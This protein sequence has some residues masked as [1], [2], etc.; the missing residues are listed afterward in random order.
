MVSRA[1]GSGIPLGV[2]EHVMVFSPAPELTVTIE[3]GGSG[4]DARHPDIH[5]HAGGQGVWQ[6]RMIRSLDVPVVMC[7]VLGGEPGRV[8]APLIKAE[9]IDLRAVQATERNPA[10]V[11]DRRDG[12]RKELARAPGVRLSR[13]TLDELYS[14]ALAEGLRAPVSVLAGVQDAGVVPPDVYRRLAG[15]LSRN[16]CKVVAD[17]TGEYLDAVLAGGLTL[18]KV[19]H[20]QL[21]NDARSGHDGAEAL[22]A[23]MHA[24][25]EDGAES[26]VVS[27]A[28]KP[29]LALIG[30]EV[31][32]VQMPSLEP[33]DSRGAGD[34]MTAGVA[35]VL[36]TGG[37]LVHAVRSGA[38]A[39]ALNVTRHGLGT[40]RAD[41]IEG[42]LER[43]KLVR[44]PSG[45]PVPE[46]DAGLARYTPSVARPVSTDDHASPSDLADRARPR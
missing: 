3:A 33:A 12:T 27:R 44:F 17:L 42:L 18:V 8:L 31:V 30:D 28:D 10:Y 22:I 7:A 25:H 32:E 38:A 5:L 43:V 1:A 45:E 37:D 2:S 35:A 9:R 21:V 13:H 11:H 36:A 29:A 34:S 24:L 23:A 16:G 4:N 6:A 14:V 20:D 39:G 19:S 46:Q 26:V 40:G 41:A 15:D